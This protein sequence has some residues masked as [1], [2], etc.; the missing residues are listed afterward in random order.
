MAADDV[1]AALRG[2]AALRRRGYTDEEIFAL[3]PQ[4]IIAAGNGDL[5]P[6]EVA[7][8]TGFI[9]PN[10]Q[11]AGSVLDYR[12]NRANLAA[13]MAAR[14]LDLYANPY[15][16]VA[17]NRAEAALKSPNLLEQERVQNTYALPDNPYE[18][19]VRD[20]LAHPAAEA[21]DIARGRQ[22]GV[23]PTDVE[24][25]SQAYGTDAEAAQRFFE[26]AARN[27]EGVRRMFGG[28]AAGGTERLLDRPVTAFDIDGNPVFTA[29]ENGPERARVEGTKVRFFPLPGVSR[30]LGARYQEQI[31][32][33][34]AANAGRKLGVMTP[35]QLSR[36]PVTVAPVAPG[37]E[38][39]M[40]Y[41]GT[42]QPQAP[43]TVAP[44][45]VYGTDQ[46]RVGPVQP[47]QTPAPRFMGA[48]AGRPA[49]GGGRQGRR[50]R[51]GE[52][53]RAPAGFAAGGYFDYATQQAIERARK[54]VGPRNVNIG[55]DRYTGAVLPDETE[56]Q[57]QARIQAQAQNY[58]P[59][60][61]ERRM[62]EQGWDPAVAHMMATGGFQSDRE[63]F[64]QNRNRQVTVQGSKG[65][66]TVT[67]S[68]GQAVR[69]AT[70]HVWRYDDLPMNASEQDFARRANQAAAYYGTTYAFPASNQSLEYYQERFAGGEPQGTP[71][72]QKRDQSLAS[73]RTLGAGAST[74]S[75]PPPFAGADS[76]GTT[77]GGA[78]TTP[79][80]LRPEQQATARQL[81]EVLR[82]N[83]LVSPEFVAALESGEIPGVILMTRAAWRSLSPENRAK[84]IGLWKSTGAI[85]D[86][87]DVL[88]LL[89]RYAPS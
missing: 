26:E 13:Q 52:G 67:L 73:G 35:E 76:G 37:G 20:Y 86:E 79:S 30:R 64:S 78:A 1:A 68:P 88:Y 34:T 50:R 57:Y 49:Q 14:Y 61:A 6:V 10:L 75:T 36:Q 62:I 89:D 7:T 74:T 33:Q 32:A 84:L 21:A 42:P 48:R 58:M 53:V 44:G 41:H 28:H 24:R 39:G 56:E 19:Y 23:A 8:G 70:G 83:T 59:S 85:S 15:N 27:P 69:D 72:V 65:R 4:V 17:A 45:E 9:S 87:A 40:P 38:P 2:I 11:A 63:F 29:A 12:Q 47:G 81:A 71:L 46:A 66:T 77:G 80:A 18:Q 51:F 25:V 43:V 60:N 82:N 16:V 5:G 54:D 55:R 3:D 31:A 22:L